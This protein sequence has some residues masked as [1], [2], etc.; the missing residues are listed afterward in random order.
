MTTLTLHS[1]E[2]ENLGDNKTYLLLIKTNNKYDA[3]TKK[4]G[5]SGEEYTTGG[6][7]KRDNRFYD[8]GMGEIS[9]RI[10]E[11]VEIYKLPEV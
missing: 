6:Y 10:D 4:W 7:Y 3:S 9:W 1:V 8:T 5:Y 11:V 2:K